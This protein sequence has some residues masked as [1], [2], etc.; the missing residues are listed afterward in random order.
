MFEK[1]ERYTYILFTLFQNITYS[2]M[3]TS[4]SDDT[5]AI[6]AVKLYNLLLYSGR[7]HSLSQLA[8]K[9]NCAKSTVSRHIEALECAFPNTITRKKA[10]G[11]IFFC[12]KPPKSVPSTSLDS[13]ELRALALCKQIGDAVL[14]QTIKDKVENA[15]L[16][17]ATLIRNYDE[18]GEINAPL[19]IPRFKGRIDYTP[20]SETIQKIIQAIDKKIVCEVLYESG[21]TPKVFHAGF[22]RLVSFH[23][24]LYAEGYLT[25]DR[26]P[27]QGCSITFAMHRIA[28]VV[29]LQLNH[30][31]E[32]MPEPS[33]YFGFME[34]EPFNVKIRFSPS[35]IRYVLEREWSTEQKATRHRDGSATLTFMAQSRFEV[36]SWVL[37]FGDKAKVLTPKFLK[38]AVAREACSMAAMYSEK[39]KY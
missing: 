20:H 15:V 4:H 24:A 26:A 28:N 10:N 39:Q 31:F 11:Q 16:Q 38:E 17:A 6:K 32:K 12:F 13:E 14:P 27:E 23:D 9:F 35:V 25:H 1:F 37:S 21:N 5:P 22:M 3:S 33:D 2:Y 30:D 36:L 29:L 19:N 7:E 18:R 34:E 8:K